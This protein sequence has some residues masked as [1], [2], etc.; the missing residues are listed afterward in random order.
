MG[1]LYQICLFFLSDVNKY[2]GILAV[3][4]LINLCLQLA[5]SDQTHTCEKEESS[6]KERSLGGCML[7][8]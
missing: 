7:F 5:L 1:K 6:E 3:Y 4:G 2:A 8:C